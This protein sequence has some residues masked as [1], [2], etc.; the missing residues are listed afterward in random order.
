MTKNL[1]SLFANSTCDEINLGKDWYES[2]RAECS[3]L[4]ATYEISLV[5]TV[6]VTAALSPACSWSRNLKDADTLLYAFDMNARGRDLPM[7]GT[8]GRPNIDKAERILL[9]E[10]PAEVL[11]SKRYKKVWNFYHNILEPNSAEYVTIDRH[12]ICAYHDIRDDRD[13][14]FARDSTYDKIA[15]G[16]KYAAKKVGLIPNQLQAVVWL[17]WKREVAWQS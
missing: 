4:A 17:V 9:G 7:V 3:K 12:A 11:Y 10:N 13:G 2:A 1:L 8:Y 6:G 15:A 16:Y 5:K 14:V